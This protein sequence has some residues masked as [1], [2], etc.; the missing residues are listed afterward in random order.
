TPVGY[1][2]RLAREKAAW[3]V[4]HEESA[5]LASKRGFIVIS[6]DTIVLLGSSVLEKPKDEND[7]A[8][9]LSQLSGATHTVHTGVCLWGRYTEVAPAENKIIS[10]SVATQVTL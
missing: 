9:M 7:A 1:V 6:A 4:D 10:F 3:V 8:R 2:D 5:Q